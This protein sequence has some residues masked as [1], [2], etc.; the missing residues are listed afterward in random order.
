MTILPVPATLTDADLSLCR[1]S[2]K[3]GIV[4]MLKSHL[5]TLYGLSEE[6]G[7]RD[8]FRLGDLQYTENARNGPQGKKLRS[9]TNLQSRN[10]K[11]PSTGTACRWPPVC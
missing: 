5:K 2:V 4:L 6:Y 7:S 11:N 10:T 3:V 1:M 8:V 9:V